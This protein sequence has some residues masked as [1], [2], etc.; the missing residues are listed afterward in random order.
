[1]TRG[2]NAPNPCKPSLHPPSRVA[3][4]PVH[5][6]Q[7][8]ETLF[9][10]SRFICLFIPSLPGCECSVQGWLPALFPPSAPCWQVLETLLSSN[11]VYSGQRSCLL[12]G[13]RGT[14]PNHVWRARLA[15]AGFQQHSQ[16]SHRVVHL[17]CSSFMYSAT[18]H[19]GRFGT[20]LEKVIG[21]GKREML[22]L[23]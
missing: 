13:Q 23:C 12:R 1:M 14:Q 4:D 22:M 7:L 18:K 6:G 19:G 16:G 17:L 3:I 5:P 2:D 10:S 9:P 21:S 15:I 20:S 11:F 8:V